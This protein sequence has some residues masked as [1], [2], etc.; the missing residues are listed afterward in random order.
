[1]PLLG[2]ALPL[3]AYPDGVGADGVLSA[4]CY[5]SARAEEVRGAAEVAAA[6]EQDVEQ[7]LRGEVPPASG[8][9]QSDDVDA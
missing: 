9:A 8:T 3:E 1:M 7:D 4:E 6:E 2:A 5:P